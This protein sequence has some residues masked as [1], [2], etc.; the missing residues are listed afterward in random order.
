[1]RTVIVIMTP[2]FGKP[3]ALILSIITHPC[4]VAIFLGRGFV[5]R[6][7]LRG[8]WTPVWPLFTFEMLNIY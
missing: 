3:V 5:L 6:Q 7:G 1:M 2:D 4:S 8:G